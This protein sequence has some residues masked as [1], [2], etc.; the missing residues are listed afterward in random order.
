MQ[1]WDSIPLI[2]RREGYWINLLQVNNSCECLSRFHLGMW[3]RNATRIT[4]RFT[5][6]RSR[7]SRQQCRE[8]V[9]TRC[10]LTQL[11]C[12]NLHALS[13]I[14]FRKRLF[15][16]SKID[17][18]ITLSIKITLFHMVKFSTLIQLHWGDVRINMHYLQ[19]LR[20]KRVIFSRRAVR[21]SSY[22]AVIPTCFRIF[23]FVQL[24]NAGIIYR[25]QGWFYPL[26]YSY[27]TWDGLGPDASIFGT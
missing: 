16:L 2:I 1:Q 21:S 26:K 24:P 9:N 17:R 11:A 7:S 6:L 4:E 27:T 13:D 12:F 15:N 3:W 20:M 23:Y 8:L 14:W 22:R 25:S 18:T 5:Y 19:F 10:V